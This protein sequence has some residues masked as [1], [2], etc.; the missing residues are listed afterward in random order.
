LIRSN[1]TWQL[2]ERPHGWN[3][4]GC[5]WVLKKKLKLDGTIG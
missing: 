2:L 4:V 3:H 5:K 1:R